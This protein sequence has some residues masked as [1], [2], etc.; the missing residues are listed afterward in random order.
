MRPQSALGYLAPAEFAIGYANVESKLRFPHLHS[1]DG[2][3]GMT[4]QLYS[5]PGCSQLRGTNGA[6]Q[7]DLQL[8]KGMMFVV[9]AFFLI[10]SPPGC[11]PKWA[12]VREPINFRFARFA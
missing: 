12:S 10:V 7:A 1:P 2:G 11:K 5:N 3:C 4:L 6:A 9:G 8:Q